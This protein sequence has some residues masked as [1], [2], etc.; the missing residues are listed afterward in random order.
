[1]HRVLI[2]NRGE[3]ACRVMRACQS[4]GLAAIAVYSDA[5]K[6]A[7]HVDT[8][9]EAHHIGPANPRDSYLKTE[10][11][12]AAAKSAKA[13]AVHP[14][15]GFLAENA[16]FAEA[17]KAAGLTWIGPDAQSIRDMGDKNA[18]RKMAQAAGVP[19]LLGSERIVA[20]DSEALMRAGEKIGYP[21]LIKSAAGGG[22]IGMRLAQSPDKL[23][24]TAEA[25]SVLAGRAFGDSGIFLERF[26]AHARHVE[27]QVFGFGNGNAV[28]FFERECSVQRRFQKI[29]E[30][31]PSPGISDAVRI[32]M[33]AA[34]VAL[35]RACRYAGAGTVE[36]IVDDDSGEFFFL[37]MNTRIQVEHAIT[38]M[39][40]GVDLVA[41]QLRLVVGASAFL[42]IEQNS[43]TT[44]GHAIECRL[45][46][47]NPAHMFLPS[48]GKLERLTFP[49]TGA[50]LRIDTGFRQGDVIT[51]HYDPMIAKIIARDHNR[52][53]AR[54]RIA[55][56]LDGARVEG[57]QSNLDFLKKCVH[58]PAFRAGKTTTNFVDM[59]KSDL[60]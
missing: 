16:D 33:C 21:L 23:T 60:I 22:G 50:N 32:E 46:A 26:V 42:D 39:V 57:V 40:C 25:T 35:T 43:I 8:A 7:L 51:P 49:E 13:D 44:T 52:D 4:E 41:L 17:V 45:Y 24:E 14:G 28:H 5:D 53:A 36:F 31:T 20:D 30:E 58:H 15:Y 10:A 55:D 56:A 18:A 29:I 12:L 59:H 34:A 19:V 38:E 2:A 1:M 9:D 48:P 11:I 47:E 3:I 37:E 27:V 6:D 54:I